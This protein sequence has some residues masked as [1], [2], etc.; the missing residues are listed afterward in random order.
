MSDTEQ[1]LWP[2]RQFNY[3]PDQD[4]RRQISL[5]FVDVLSSS[6]IDYMANLPLRMNIWGKL[7]IQGGNLLCTSWALKQIK[8]SVEYQDNCYVWVSTRHFELG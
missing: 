2:P 3:E 5:Y 7:Q 6:R 1:I 8:L 4:L